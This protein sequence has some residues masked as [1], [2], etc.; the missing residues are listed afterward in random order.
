MK[1]RTSVD[2]HEAF[3]VIDTSRGGHFSLG[4][5]FCWV[6]G[7]EEGLWLMGE[8]LRHESF[9]RDE[10]TISIEYGSFYVKTNDYNGKHY[11]EQMKLRDPQH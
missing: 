10:T 5:F 8:L 11:G 6:G 1:V 4:C 3:Y 7:E 2:R 9:G